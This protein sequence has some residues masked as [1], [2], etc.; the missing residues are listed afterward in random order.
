MGY[1]SSFSRIQSLILELTEVKIVLHIANGFAI[2]PSFKKAEV[3]SIRVAAYDG[4]RFQGCSRYIPETHGSVIS[5]S[6]DN[7]FAIAGASRRRDFAAVGNE[8][9]GFHRVSIQRHLDHSDDLVE[10]RVHEI[11]GIICRDTILADTWHNLD[12]IQWTAVSGGER[13]T[14]AAIWFFSLLSLTFPQLDLV[15]VVCANKTT[16]FPSNG[17]ERC[18][19]IHS[20]G[21]RGVFKL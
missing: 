15:I 5:S 10:C 13:C 4:A 3:C 11:L 2:F 12:F 17:C 14:H 9:R 6:R 8:S 16:R 21:S 1:F 19:N 20:F 7:V 18:W